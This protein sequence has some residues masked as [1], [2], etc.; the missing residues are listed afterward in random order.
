MKRLAL[1]LVGGFLLPFLYTLVVGPLTPYFRNYP[2]FNFLLTVRWPV[3]LI[4]QANATPSITTRPAQDRVA[5]STGE[6]VIMNAYAMLL[7]IAALLVHTGCQSQIDKVSSQNSSPD[8]TAAQASA[9]REL[10]KDVERFASSDNSE[11]SAAWNNLMRHD[12]QTLIKELSRISS[13]LPADDRDRVFIAYTFCKMDHE[14]DT[15]RKVIRS[16][17]S[18]NPPYRDLYGDWVASL[19]GNLVIDGHKDLLAPLFQ[20]AEWSDGAMSTELA[21]VYSQALL[22]DPESFVTTLST[23]SA[24]TRNTVIRLLHDHSLTAEQNE[25]VKAYLK[26]VVSSSKQGRVAAEILKT[27]SSSE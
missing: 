19:M 22:M 25:K 21:G 10:V 23:E 4:L 16:A 14:F 3:L 8:A 11:A 6:L 2:T 18:K 17:L 20:A 15:N 26:T 1:S 9:D 7:L 13:A 5:Q 24:K 12:R 27:L